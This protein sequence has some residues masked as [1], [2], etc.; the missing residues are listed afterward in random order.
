MHTKTHTHTH[1]HTLP[2][3]KRARGSR[4]GQG[5]PGG[6][7]GAGPFHSQTNEAWFTHTPG[8]KVVYPAF[9]SDAKGLLLSSIEDPN[10]VMFFEHKA[11]YRSIV[12]DVPED[13]Y[14]TPI[15]TGAI[16]QEGN[17]LSIITYGQPVHWAKEIS[18]EYLKKGINIEIIDLR[19]LVP[20]DKTLVEQSIQKTN[21]A[22]VLHEANLTG[23]VGGEIASYISEHFFEL[24][25]APV[26]RLGSLDTPVPFS[27]KIEK[28]VYL[29][30][31]RIKEKINYL[32]E[33]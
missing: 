21:R 8:L 27:P 17:D 3:Y 33:Y 11:L 2:E 24:L 31:S 4:R 5:A 15:G 14:T 6:G 20:W 26:V 7:V 19:S 16:V 25:D 28:N 29:P 12:N 23:G 32:L 30:I 13:Y 1:T 22:L 9:P 10:P 18:L